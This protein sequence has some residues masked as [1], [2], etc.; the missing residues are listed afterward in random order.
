MTVTSSLVSVLQGCSPCQ[1]RR[2][3]LRCATERGSKRYLL[4]LFVVR[5][6]RFQVQHCVP[7]MRLTKQRP[8]QGGREVPISLRAQHEKRG[9][10]PDRSRTRPYSCLERPE[11]DLG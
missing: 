3:F 11:R 2:H 9:R 4:F 7:C 1:Y 8:C 6:V 10:T 5:L